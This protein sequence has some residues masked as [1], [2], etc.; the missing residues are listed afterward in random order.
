MLNYINNCKEN[1]SEIKITTFDG[2][3]IIGTIDSTTADYVLIDETCAFG[4]IRVVYFKDIK[5]VDWHNRPVQVEKNKNRWCCTVVRDAEGKYYA[6]MEIEGVEVRDLPEHVAYKTLSAAIL[7]KT[8]VHILKHKDMLWERLSDTE[9]I[10]TIDASQYRG[11]GKDCRVS[12][13]DRIA[14]WKPCFD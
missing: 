13:A 6:R 14:G 3:E 12:V 11:E 8:G 2:E 5:D 1:C 4:D 9:K 7:D 10:A